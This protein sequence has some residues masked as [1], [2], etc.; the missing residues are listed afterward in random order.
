MTH[1]EVRLVEVAEESWPLASPFVI[2]RGAKTS[3]VVVVAYVSDGQHTGR[4]EAVPYAHYGETISGVIDA[5]R[6]LAGPIDRS[7]LPALLPPGAARNA[8]D[9]ALWDL[10]AKAA[11]RRVW[12]LAGLV[13]PKP[14]LT[15]YTLSLDTPFAMSEMAQKASLHTLIKLKLGGVDDPE[16]MAAV[17][18]ARPD[19]RLIVDANEAWSADT[20]E[21]YLQAAANARVELIEQPLP[22]GADDALA[23]VSRGI[24][25]CADESVHTCADLD[26]LA[27]RYDAVN[28]KL[29]KAGGLTEAL[30]L[31]R[32]AHALG[33]KV[34]IGSMVATSLG[35]APALL[36]AQGADWVDLDGPLLLA[37]DR[38]PGLKIE[39]GH[40]SPPEPE[41]WG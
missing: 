31:S 29:D 19:A 27:G 4:G 20:L 37:K 28:V 40:I 39:D 15:A 24:P 12:Q 17:R 13:E 3:A 25:I 23:K 21:A 38:T 16:R 41:L 11:H 30:A 36:L 33:L 26:D 14:L 34:M 35:V 2:S 1:G 10:E 22:A 18:A 7:R 8:V 32:K 5:L 6:T 9:C